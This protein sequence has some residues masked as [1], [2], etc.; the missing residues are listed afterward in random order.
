MGV[1]PAQH[2]KTVRQDHK[3]AADRLGLV[4]A[5][6]GFARVK[7]PGEGNRHAPQKPYEQVSINSVLLH[8]SFSLYAGA[9]FSAIQSPCTWCSRNT[10]L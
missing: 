7:M 9:K 2:R 4:L 5:F 1:Q 6:L 8:G 3:A 10:V